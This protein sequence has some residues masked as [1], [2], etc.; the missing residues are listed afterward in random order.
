MLAGAWVLVF[1]PLFNALRSS[2]PKWFAWL[3]LFPLIFSVVYQTT[4]AVLYGM[5]LDPKIYRM[6]PFFFDPDRLVEGFIT[7][8]QVRSVWRLFESGAV[9]KPAKW[10]S[11]LAIAVWFTVAQIRAWPYSK[12]RNGLKR[13]DA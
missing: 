4:V 12:E 2:G 9:L 10:G 1:V 5:F 11:V 8:F 3:L 13:N 6:R 7:A